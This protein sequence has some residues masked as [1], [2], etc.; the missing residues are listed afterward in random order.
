[1]G[2]DGYAD[3]GVRFDRLNELR[4]GKGPESGR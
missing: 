2:C 4:E 3:I 1:M